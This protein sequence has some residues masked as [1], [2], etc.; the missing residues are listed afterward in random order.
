MLKGATL[1]SLIISEPFPL[2][3]F[4]GCGGAVRAWEFSMA[5]IIA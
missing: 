5:V 1:K 3:G 2:S 4:R